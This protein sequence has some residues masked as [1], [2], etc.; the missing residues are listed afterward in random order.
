MKARSAGLILGGILLGFGM[1]GCSHLPGKPGFRAETLRPD[2]TLD[3]KT[4]Y[5]QNCAACHG[6]DG[7]NAS[8][9]PLRNPAY[10]A[11]AG[12]DNMLQIVAH[13]IPHSLMPAFSQSGGGMLT[14]QQVARIV[15]GMISDWGDRNAVD[16]VKMP[17]YSQPPD[18]DAAAGKA[19]FELHCALCHGADGMGLSGSAAKVAHAATG[20][21]VDPTY[22]SLITTQGLRDIVVSGLPKEGMPDWRG[23][24]NGTPLTDKEVTD[25]VAWL[26][27]Q[28][29]QFPGQPFQSSQPTGGATGQ[30]D[31]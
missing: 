7:L 16:G 12:R 18:G 4:L 17:G 19:A 27:A 25:I 10:L 5:K 22:L 23:D 29:V 9:F 28:R 30:H 13:G 1:A 26:V 11:W 2:Q 3:F 14:D 24:G 6:N 31:K 21:I 20:S 8:A 15:D